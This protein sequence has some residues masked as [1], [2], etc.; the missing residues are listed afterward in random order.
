MGTTC[1]SCLDPM[2]R[3]G[4]SSAYCRMANAKTFMRHNIG[5]ENFAIHK[6]IGRGS[7]GKVYLVKE[8]NKQAKNESDQI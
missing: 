8:V 3:E 1:L 7:F 6:V 4:P 2:A 5:R